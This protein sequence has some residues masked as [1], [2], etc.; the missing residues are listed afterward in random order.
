MLAGSL[1]EQQ[2]LVACGATPCGKLALLRSG[3]GVTPLMLDGPTLPVSEQLLMAKAGKA[4]YPAHSS[5]P[6]LALQRQRAVA[7]I[8]CKVV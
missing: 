4:W 5:V 2:L 7:S 3:V 8:A 1:P 6:L